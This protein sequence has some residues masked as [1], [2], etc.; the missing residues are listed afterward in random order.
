MQSQLSTSTSQR[1]SDG[2]ILALWQ[3]FLLSF[4]CELAALGCIIHGPS[5]GTFDM[6]E[7]FNLAACDG[8][9]LALQKGILS[10]LR[11]KVFS[12]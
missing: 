7:S 12:V 11:L 2:V 8:V 6:N 9:I 10:H 5:F 4:P 3:Y 1:G